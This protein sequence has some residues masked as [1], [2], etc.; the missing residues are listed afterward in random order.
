M[1]AELAMALGIGA[2]PPSS[3]CSTSHVA[4]PTVPDRTELVFGTAARAVG[5]RCLSPE[6]G[7][8]ARSVTRDFP[9]GGHPSGLA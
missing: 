5:T 4:T 9:R 7:R 8:D 3:P 1:I 2:R 6:H